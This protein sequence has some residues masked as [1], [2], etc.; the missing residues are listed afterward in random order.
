MTARSIPHACVPLGFASALLF[1]CFRA[2]ESDRKFG[3]F[4]GPFRNS[5][6]DLRGNSRLGIYAWH[7]I[8]Y[9]GAT[10]RHLTLALSQPFE[11]IAGRICA[12]GRVLA[13]ASGPYYQICTCAPKSQARQ[14]IL[15]DLLP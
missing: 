11:L 13:L 3:P 2:V 4:E 12:N 10:S 8:S 5:A 1:H 9:L 6:L 7:R 15:E 14:G